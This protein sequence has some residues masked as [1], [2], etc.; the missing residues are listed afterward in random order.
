MLKIYNEYSS[1][2]VANYYKLNNSSYYNPHQ[3][4]INKIFTEYIIPYIQALGV[5]NIITYNTKIDQKLKIL[6]LACGNG[7]VSRIVNN[8][9]P[10]NENN[11]HTFIKPFIIEGCDPYFNNEYVNYNYSFQDIANGCLYTKNLKFDL[12]TCCY[13][14]HLL[15]TSWYYSFFEELSLITQ[16]F[17]IITPSKKIEINHPRWVIKNKIRKNKITIIFL[18]I[19]LK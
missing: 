7:L 6:D 17:I 8:I 9:I 19:N 10:V 16:H 12:V 1:L 18:V 15:D 11:N 2:G 4:K 5:N 14:F 13:A 3:D